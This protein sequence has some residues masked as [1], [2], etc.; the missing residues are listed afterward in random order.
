M[1]RLLFRS[2]PRRQPV[3]HGLLYLVGDSV[4]REDIVVAEGPQLLAKPII[5]VMLPL[6][7]ALHA[8]L[9]VYFCPD[10]H[11]FLLL[12][13]LF[14]LLLLYLLQKLV[15]CLGILSTEHPFVVVSQLA[16]VQDC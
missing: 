2:N 5:E 7:I 13:G 3:R 10:S 9:F 6:F 8:A 4:L 11:L 1:T 12:S 15:L 16:I 14:K